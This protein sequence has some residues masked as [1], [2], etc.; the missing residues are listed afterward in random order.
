MISK[1]KKGKGWEYAAFLLFLVLYGIVLI[2][3]EPWF[4]EAQSWQIAKCASLREMLFEIPHYEGHPPFWW[5]LLAVPAKLGVPF[6]LGLKA[7]GALLTVS[8]VWLILFKM[9]YP[10]LM[11]LVLPFTYFVFYQYGV[12]VR[13]YTL[14]LLAGLLLALA[15]PKREEKPFAFTAIL[16]L[17]C[18]SSAYGIVFAGGVALCWVWELV[19]EKGVRSFFHSLFRD[20]RTVSLFLLL[21]LAVLL[22]LEFMPRKDTMITSSGGN[23]SFL[24]CFVVALLTFLSECTITTSTWFAMDR[25]LLQK[26]SIPTAYL[27]TLGVIGILLWTIIIGASSKRSLKYI[28]IPYFL[29]SCFAAGVYFSSHHV[30]IFL[31]LLLFWIGI[32]FQDDQRFEVGKLIIQRIAKT[33]KDILLMKKTAAAVCIVCLFVPACWTVFASIYDFQYDYSFGRTASSFLNKH[34]LEKTLILS[35]W[36]DYFS[37]NGNARQENVFVQGN[38]VL[39]SAYFDHNMC[40]NL[41]DGND[42]EAYMHYKQATIEENEKARNA[43]KAEGIPD[44]LLSTPNLEAVY[45]KEISYDDFSL[46]QML[47]YNYIWKNQYISYKLPLYMRN[48]LLD[49]YQIEP[50]TDVSY[51]YWTNGF[52]ITEEM[53]EA[54]ENGVP[55]EEI[56]KPYLDAMFGP[57]E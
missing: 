43:W 36:N 20:R 15:F 51:E 12:I 48:D 41:N 53:R 57:E 8:C 45:G 34:G 7:V 10:R 11:R 50:I 16:M 19:Q 32:L 56:L 5:L 49:Q 24:F 40:Y 14:M 35:S 2:S 46:V 23:N 38:S 52:S 33:E 6:E 3:H 31:I 39:L 47:E 17:L 28:I 18:L 4:D 22:I 37:E 27:I 29:L 44:L 21:V 26:A 9:P 25:V 1:L 54:Y 42:Q 55:V 30:G 13:P